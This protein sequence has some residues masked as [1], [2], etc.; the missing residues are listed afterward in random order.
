MRWFF[1]KPE[2]KVFPGPHR[3][4]S[5]IWEGGREL[6]LTTGEVPGGHKY[7]KGALPFIVGFEGQKFCGN[8]SDF[9]EGAIFNPLGA[10]PKLFGLVARCCLPNEAL[11]GFDVPLG[12]SLDVAAI[13]GLQDVPIG[14]TIETVAPPGLQDVPI[15]LTVETVAPP[16]LQDVPIG[17]TI[18]TVAPPGLQDVPIGLTVE[19]VAPPGLDEIFIGLG[20]ED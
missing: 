2:A 19:T 3:F 17:L 1:C 13:P 6:Q 10:Y 12:L 7:T 20:V 18:E 4:S 11:Q 15:G 8:L 5:L 16:G 14:L 9:R